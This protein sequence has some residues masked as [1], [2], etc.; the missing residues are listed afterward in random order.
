MTIYISH[1]FEDGDLKKI[2]LEMGTIF[3]NKRIGIE[4]ID[5]AAGD[6]LDKKDAQIDLYRGRIGELLEKYPL[7]IHGPFLDLCPHSFDRYIREA[8]MLRYE[9]TYQMAKKMGAKHVIFHSCLIPSIYYTSIWEENSLPFWND[10]LGDKDDSIQIH[11]ENVFDE[12]YVPIRNLISKVNHPAF[13]MCLDVGHV[14]CFSKQPVEEWLEEMSPIIGHIHLHNND[15]K[16]DLHWQLDK[17]TIN[18][19]TLL[20]LIEK[21][22]PQVDWTLEMNTGLEVEAS[23]EFLKQQLQM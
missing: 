4:T 14:H 1:L 18:M 11:L 19:E 3:C 8:T 17:G 22:C 15:G 7:S 20:P 6:Y 23:L 9:E 10:F 13:S 5:F 16:K 12:D 2:M 21:Y